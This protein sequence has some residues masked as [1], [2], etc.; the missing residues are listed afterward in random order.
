MV[1]VVPKTT[2]R[3]LTFAQNLG[4]QNRVQKNC[5]FW[6]GRLSRSSGQTP[7]QDSPEQPYRDVG[8]GVGEGYYSTTGETQIS[9]TYGGYTRIQTFLL[10]YLSQPLELVGSLQTDD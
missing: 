3:F 8:G 6:S 7:T 9:S 5:I 2:C 1:T 4:V 10:K